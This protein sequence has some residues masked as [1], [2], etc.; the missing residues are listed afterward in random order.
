[1]NS[2]IGWVGGKK[3]LRNEII[4]Q[5][6]QSFERY[7]EVFG[8]AGWVLFGKERSK[9]EV[10]N[11][12]DSHLINLYMQIKYNCDKLV[13]E[14]DWI[15]SRELFNNYKISAFSDNITDIQKAAQYLYLIKHS[16]GSTRKSFKTSVVGSSVINMLSD[17]KER[18]KNVII[19]NRDFEN[20]IKTYDRDNVL[21]YLD[22]PYVET[23]K[24]YRGKFS[25]ADHKRLKNVLDNIQGKFILSYND[26]ELVR[27]LY[28]DYSIKYITRINMLEPSNSKQFKEVIIKNY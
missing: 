26:C 8:G 22:P 24:Y 2:F 10:F 12:A 27:E 23:E 11:D 25:I 19:E 7:I 4:A 13:K 17:V 28:K 9:F 5:F 18:L 21:F 20:L 3:A 15:H 6:P 1:M 14:Y 16:F